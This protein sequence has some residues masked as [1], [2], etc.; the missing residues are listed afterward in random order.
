MPIFKPKQL[1][2]ASYGYQAPLGATAHGWCCTNYDCSTSDHEVVRRWPFPCRLCGSLTDPLFD[3]PWAHE[4]RGV[5]LDWL[6]RNV[7]ERGG[8][9]YQDAWIV[10]SYT[11]A[12]LRGNGDDAHQARVRARRHASER[13]A[14]A[15]WSPGSVFYPMVL[16]ELNHGDL[17]AAGDDLSYWLSISTSVDVETDNSHRT[18]CRQVIDMAIRFLSAEGVTHHR[19]SDRIRSGCLRLA[20]GA[21]PVLSREL[22]AGVT[23]LA[24]S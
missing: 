9:F 12:V 4:A 15:W 11:D 16:D 14:E 23:R 10:W 5:E 17:D 1:P 21:F 24:R 20:E 2:R 22:Q 8:G 13:T 3:E 7:P 6:Q 18:N 19:T